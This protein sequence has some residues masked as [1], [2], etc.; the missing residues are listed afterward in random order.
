MRPM[1]KQIVTSSMLEIK[2]YERMSIIIIN[3]IP[4]VTQK[5]TISV[6]AGTAIK[7]EF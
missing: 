4:S 6:K 7:H 3:S 1:T 5:T 2:Q